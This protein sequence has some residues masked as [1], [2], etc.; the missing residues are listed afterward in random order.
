MIF[1]KYECYIL[2]QLYE[3]KIM[4]EEN[5]KTKYEEEI[6][7]SKLDLIQSYKKTLGFPNLKEIS[8]SY[9]L[10][11]KNNSTLIRIFNL[12]NKQLEFLNLADFGIQQYWSN[13][14]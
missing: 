9:Y 4:A 14:K 10:V 7:R 5:F 12:N 3:A 6:S 1:V 2:G 11:D 13:K 8:G